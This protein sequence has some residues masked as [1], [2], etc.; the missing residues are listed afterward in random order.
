MLRDRYDPMRVRVRYAHLEALQCHRCAYPRGS[1]ASDT[2]FSIIT[3]HRFCCPPVPYGCHRL[4]IYRHVERTRQR[5]VLFAGMLSTDN[6]LSVL[7]ADSVGD[8]VLQLFHTPTVARM[9]LGNGRG[10]FSDVTRTVP[11]CQFGYSAN[12]ALVADLR[13]CTPQLQRFLE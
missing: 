8:D 13:R 12:A 9:P 3:T 11:L 1:T 2:P 4:N 10:W 6:V 5:Y 7:F